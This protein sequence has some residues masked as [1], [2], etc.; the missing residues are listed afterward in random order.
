[1]CWGGGKRGEGE[2]RKEGRKEGNEFV[3]ICHH[4]SDSA[5]RFSFLIELLPEHV[6]WGPRSIVYVVKKSKPAIP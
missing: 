1:M 2:R 3:T 5:L 4:P 6:F